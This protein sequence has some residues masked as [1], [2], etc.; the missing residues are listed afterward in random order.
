MIIFRSNFDR[1]LIKNTVLQNNFP[2]CTD[3]DYE[4]DFANNLTQ[5][6]FENDFAYDLV[7]DTV[8][9]NDLAYDFAS[10]CSS[11]ELSRVFVIDTFFQN[12]VACDCALNTV[13]QNDKPCCFRFC[14][15]KGLCTK[16]QILNHCDQKNFAYDLQ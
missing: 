14:L 1:I 9:Q 10:Y 11:Q 8:I 13:F 2:D 5:S 7:L 3:S 16:L 4:N 12:D 6:V 15:P